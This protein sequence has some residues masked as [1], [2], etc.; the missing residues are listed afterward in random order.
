[1]PQTAKIIGNGVTDFRETDISRC[2]EH[3]PGEEFALVKMDGEIWNRHLLR[4]AAHLPSIC[5]PAG[6]VDTSYLNPHQVFLGSVFVPSAYF[7]WQPD[8]Q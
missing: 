4:F 6:P 2:G 7:P 5:R 3:R 8:R 1:M